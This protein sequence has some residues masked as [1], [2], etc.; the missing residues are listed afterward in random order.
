[1]SSNGNG[2]TPTERRMLE[3]LKD[4]LPHTRQELHACLEDDLAGITA[5]QAHLSRIRKRLR[6]IGEEI[7]CEYYLRTLHYR[8]VR[9]L[10][11]PYD[12]RS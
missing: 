3:L 8:H 4:G 1:M 9:L 10:N 5:I 6:G 12:G 11:S 2:Y 7:V